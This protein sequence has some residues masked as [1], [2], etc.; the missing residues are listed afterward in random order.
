MVC[1]LMDCL[2]NDYDGRLRQNLEKCSETKEKIMILFSIFCGG[3]EDLISQKYIYKQFLIACLSNPSDK[4]ISYNAKLREKYTSF[5]REIHP[6]INS[7]KIYDSII[8]FFIASQSLENYD[9]RKHIKSFINK[10][11]K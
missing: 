1:E 11:I 5:L 10:E 4:L 9:L 2:Q 6:S 7:E 8:G 3:S